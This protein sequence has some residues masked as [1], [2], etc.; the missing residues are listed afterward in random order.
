MP[1]RFKRKNTRRRARPRRGRP[2]TLYRK[3]TTRAVKSFPRQIQSATY[4]PKSRLIKFRDVR[5]YILVDDAGDVST[6]ALPPS[7]LVGANNP[8]KFVHSQQGNWGQ[9][10]LGSKGAAVPN[11]ATWISDI[12]PTSSAT[13]QYLNG[14]CLGAKI[15][16]TACPMP[17][18]NEADDYQ[19]IITMHLQKN[20]RGGNWIGKSIS[21]TFNGELVSET[22]QVKSANM[23]LNHGGTPRGASITMF[24]SFRKMN[25]QPGRQNQNIF[26]YDSDPAEKD[27][28]SLCFL[29]G[30]SNKYGLA[31]PYIRLPPLRVTVNISYIVNCFEP[32]NRLG[33]SLNEGTE[34]TSIPNVF[35][36]M[37]LAKGIP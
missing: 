22:P 2:R 26:H 21:Q 7:M 33:G 25:N 30:D 35:Q 23:Y 17:T 18:A 4:L 10:N 19:D 27:F 34:L 36:A 31:S 24:Y 37:S 20:T 9:T 14:S 28:F 12:V 3:R 29:P 15:T 11:L 8:R 6:G 13:A 32:N 16:V 5:Q 1:V